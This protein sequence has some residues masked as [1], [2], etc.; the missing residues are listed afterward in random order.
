MKAWEYCIEFVD[1]PTGLLSEQ[2]LTEL[3]QDGWE[4]VTAHTFE[5]RHQV[6]GRALET[7][8]VFKREKRE[9]DQ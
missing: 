3:G 8:W 5:Y 4:L 7:A 9:G 6:H 1:T 2:R